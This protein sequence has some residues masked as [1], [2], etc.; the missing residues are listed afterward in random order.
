MVRS[1]R[2]ARYVFVRHYLPPWIYGQHIA[3]MFET[4]TTRV[5]TDLYEA[6]RLNDVQRRFWEPKPPKKLYDLVADPWET[7]NLADSADHRAVLDEMRRAPRDRRRAARED[8]RNDLARGGRRSGVRRRRR[9]TRPRQGNLPPRMA[10]L[11]R[12]RR[13]DAA[14]IGI[15]RERLPP[16]EA[17]AAMDAA[18]L[19]AALD[20]NPA[21]PMFNP[22]LRQLFHV[23]DPIAAD[24][25]RDVLDALE[26]YRDPIARRIAAN[27]GDRHLRPL[28]G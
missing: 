27:I 15:Q 4:P 20:H 18:A 9:G 28:F 21:Q 3:Y 13:P 10:P 1:V 26:R 16:P 6:G 19:V 8:R 12:A 14:V 25:G 11:R 23:A 24:A 2:S 5:W 22:D 7:R 17:D